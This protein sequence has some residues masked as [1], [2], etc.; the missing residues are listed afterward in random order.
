MMK[1]YQQGF[2]L[3]EM[4]IVIGIIGILA[5]VAIP[6]YQNYLERGRLAA[7]KKIMISAKQFYENGKLDKPNNFSLE[8]AV[9]KTDGDAKVAASQTAVETYI[10]GQI[11]ESG[12][13]GHYRISPRIVGNG[14]SS[15]MTI[16]TIPSDATKR[17][18][19]M[20]YRGI[21]YKCAVGS[22]SGALDEEGKKPDNCGDERF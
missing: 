3:L 21:T 7:A 1:Q 2:T 17:G 6:A 11:R 19:Y 15:Y 5:A 9:S 16:V 18:L 22:I 10:T 12:I 8:T 13:N 14:K 20:D 4:M